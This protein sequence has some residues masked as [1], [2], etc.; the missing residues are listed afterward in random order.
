MGVWW[1]LRQ[2]VYGRPRVLAAGAVAMLLLVGY[3]GW[4]S[5]RWFSGDGTA[6]AADT[7]LYGVKAAS[8]VRS[9]DKNGR[10]PAYASAASSPGTPTIVSTRLRL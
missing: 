8:T 5:A 2:W 6:Q 7:A 4:Q 1:H 3:G 10:V 9:E